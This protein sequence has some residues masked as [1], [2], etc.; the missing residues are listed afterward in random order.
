MPSS[1]PADPHLDGAPPGTEREAP[2]HAPRERVRRALA[3]GRRAEVTG[4]AGSFRAL[5]VRD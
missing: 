5:L 4:V 2:S 3:D 1:S